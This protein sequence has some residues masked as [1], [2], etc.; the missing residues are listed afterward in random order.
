MKSEW[1]YSSRKGRE[2]GFTFNFSNHFDQLPYLFRL[3]FIHLNHSMWKFCTF[4]FKLQYYFRLSGQNLIPDT[5]Y[6]NLDEN[7]MERKVIDMLA[8][9]YTNFAK[10]A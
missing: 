2:H 1:N 10:F 6:D 4:E 5:G 3:N 7:S 9:F 8:D